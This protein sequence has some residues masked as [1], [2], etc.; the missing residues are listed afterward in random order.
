M[1]NL[2]MRIQ[3]RML[4]YLNN[5]QL[6]QREML[7]KICSSR[8]NWLM[9][10]HN[11]GNQADLVEAFIIAK[12]IEGCSEKSLKYYRKTIEALLAGIGKRLNKSPPNLRA[13]TSELSD[14]KRIKQGND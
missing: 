4:P 1:T 14:T 2:S 12:R 8:G 11:E 6:K 9:R 5:E 3:R 13:A 7:T 10:E